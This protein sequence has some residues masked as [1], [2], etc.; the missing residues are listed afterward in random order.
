MSSGELKHILYWI[1]FVL[2]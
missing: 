1:P 2:C